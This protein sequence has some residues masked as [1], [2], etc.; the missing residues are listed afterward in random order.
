[1]SGTLLIKLSL[2]ATQISIEDLIR[3]VL[4][5]LSYINVD[6]LESGL[7]H[8][9]VEKEVANYDELETEFAAHDWT[10]AL[11]MHAIHCVA[12]G[13]VRVCSAI[14]LDDDQW[15]CAVPRAT[16]ETAA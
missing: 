10:C 12:P 2:E 5:E 6:R 8:V 14:W 1:M 7:Q 15:F 13:A 16:R 11:L 4:G 9:V 3:G